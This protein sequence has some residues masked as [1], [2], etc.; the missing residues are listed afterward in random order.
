MITIP[1]VLVRVLVATVL[2][3]AVGM[4]RE[5]SERAAGLRTHAMVGLG[6]AAFM[7]ISAFGFKDILGAPAVVLDPSRVAA[8]IVTGIGFLG[9]G[10][11]IFQREMVR[12]LT[13]AASIWAVAA[14]GA[15][16]G[17]GM[18]VL[19]GS[20]T[21]LTLGVLAGLKPIET[22][23]FRARRSRSLSLLFDPGA[24]SLSKI[25]AAMEQEGYSVDQ[26]VISPGQEGD[27]DRL[28][29]VFG[30][31]SIKNLAPLIDTLRHFDGVRQISSEK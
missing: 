22:R 3:G 8:Q 28:E 17:G 18:Y 14:I 12:G 9:A 11:I 19:A 25:E 23:W 26:I 29:L 21:A 10:T 20:T 15:A 7:V 16:V 1:E 2:G 5:R 13:T 6:A 27:L 4:E 30:V 24:T 31:G